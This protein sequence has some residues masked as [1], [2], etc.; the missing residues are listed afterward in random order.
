VN[1]SFA[2]A[3]GGGLKGNLAWKGEPIPCANLVAFPGA[4][5][6]ARDLTKK[7]ALGDLGDLGELARDFGALGAAA[8]VV[9]VTGVFSASGTVAF[10]S[11]DLSHAKVATVAKNACGLALF[12][13]PANQAK[14]GAP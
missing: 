13:G 5:A 10:Q 6:A 8:G 12:Q 2:R 9:R 3:A 1:G 14:E 7:A 4:E 11:A